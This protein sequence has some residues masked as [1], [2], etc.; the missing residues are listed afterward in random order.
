MYTSSI[1]TIPDRTLVQSIITHEDTIPVVIDQV[2]SIHVP[3]DPVVTDP[4]LSDPV[5]TDQVDTGIVSGN[6]RDPSVLYTL[7]GFANDGE[8]THDENGERVA[9]T[10]NHQPFHNFWNDVIVLS[11]DCTRD[12]E[13]KKV[14]KTVFH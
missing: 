3:R 14:S 8:I 9:R 6:Q 11:M 13:T 5:L 2:T 4:V 1:T 12:P 7:P 10:S